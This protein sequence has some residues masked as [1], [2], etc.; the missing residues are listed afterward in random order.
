MAKKNLVRL[1]FEL[2]Q[3]AALQKRFRA[4]AD[5]VMREHGLSAGERKLLHEGDARKITAL[6]GSA[7]PMGPTIVKLSGFG[8]TIVKTA[9]VAKRKPRKP[10]KR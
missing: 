2:S 9:S 7:W 3:D 8:P 1:L 10:A 5:G 4:D 6:L